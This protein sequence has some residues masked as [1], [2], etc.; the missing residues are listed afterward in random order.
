MSAALIRSPP[1]A[2]T[3]RLGSDEGVWV[4]VA[5]RAGVLQTCVARVDAWSRLWS[6]GASS[7][8]A[9]KPPVTGKGPPA[10]RPR[11]RGPSAT[12]GHPELSLGRAEA[13]EQRHLSPLEEDRC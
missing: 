6:S 1:S 12:P 5:Q 9:T 10:A 4:T 11:S 7:W 8:N 13:R 2:T 3:W